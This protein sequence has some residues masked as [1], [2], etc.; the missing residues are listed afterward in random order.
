MNYSV[1]FRPQV[2]VVCCSRHL[3]CPSAAP[4]TRPHRLSQPQSLAAISFCPLAALLQ[5]A[6]LLGPA[7]VHGVV[8]MVAPNTQ[9]VYPPTD[10]GILRSVFEMEEMKG[11]QK[12]TSNPWSVCC[13]MHSQ[14]STILTKILMSSS[15]ESDLPSEPSSF[16]LLSSSSA[17][18]AGGLD[19]S[20]PFC[21]QPWRLQMVRLRA[22]A[23]CI[24]STS[25]R[26]AVD[27]LIQSHPNFGFPPW[28]A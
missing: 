17:V 16:E 24:D 19:G 25:E 27:C 21:I 20:A 23:F 11:Q 8:G 14:C 7:H 2:W 26:W 28:G 5:Q 4:H 12:A 18:A 1:D 13:C 15:S 22:P 10:G 3:K 6:P 9:I